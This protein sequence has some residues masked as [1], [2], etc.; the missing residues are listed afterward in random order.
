MAF[1]DF[2]KPNGQVIDAIFTGGVRVAFANANGDDG[3]FFLLFVFLDSP[4][5][6]RI[7]GVPQK[8]PGP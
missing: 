3:L 7:T 6:Q 1:T 4:L 2:T 5:S 8:N